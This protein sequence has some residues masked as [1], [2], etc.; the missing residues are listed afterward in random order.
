MAKL[1]IKLIRSVASRPYF[2]RRTIEALGFHRL[3]ETRILPDN[4]AIRGMIA[5]VSHMVEWK[6][7]NEG[8]SS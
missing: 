7:V 3:N 1:E 6:Q 8:A 4:A 2:H 5:K